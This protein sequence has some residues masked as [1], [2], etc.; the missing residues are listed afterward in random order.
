MRTEA[1]STPPSRNGGTNLKARIISWIASLTLLS[2]LV[3]C[4]N[5]AAPQGNYGSISG[6]VKSTS[7]QPIANALV[8]VD[9]GPNTTSKPDGTY[10]LTNAPVTSP[11]SP[12]IVSVK[13]PAGYQD[14]PPQTNVQVTAGQTTPNINFTLSPA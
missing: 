3:A 2:L 4:S 7:G 14:P 6:I 9:N 1:H 13:A 11:L 10:L 5:P 8:T 12:D